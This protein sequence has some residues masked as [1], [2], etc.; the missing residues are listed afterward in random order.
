[1]AL[2]T[3]YQTAMCEL[4]R[5]YLEFHGCESACLDDIYHW[6]LTTGRWEPPQRTARDQFRREMAQSLSMERIVD[7]QGRPVRRNHAAKE[8]IAGGQRFLWADLISAT[9]DHM[10]KSLQQRRHRLVAMAI[11]H[12]NDT[13]SYNDNNIHG[14]QLEFDYNIQLDIEEHFQPSDYPDE[15]PTN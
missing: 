1:M 9:P 5:E 2:K 14:A 15:R 10:Q 8:G 11:R 13:D 12:K 6:A 7:P 3:S 4:F